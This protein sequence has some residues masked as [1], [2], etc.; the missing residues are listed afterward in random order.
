MATSLLGT[1]Q[2]KPL[3]KQRGGACCLAP[4]HT[5]RLK[6]RSVHLYG[7]IEPHNTRE[8]KALGLLLMKKPKLK[9]HGQG[10]EAL[11]RYQ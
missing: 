10:P 11:S 5:A 2:G 3:A 7:L 6:V 4:W 1:E 8:K 9:G